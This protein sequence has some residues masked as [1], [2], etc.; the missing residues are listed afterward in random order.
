MPSNATELHNHVEVLPGSRG[1]PLRPY[2][3][4]HGA[5]T[6][7]HSQMEISSASDHSLRIDIVSKLPSPLKE[8]VSTAVHPSRDRH[9]SRPVYKKETEVRP[10]SRN[11]APQP[12]LTTWRLLTALFA[13]PSA[14]S[15]TRAP[16][17]LS[18]VRRA[19]FCATSLVRR[20][21]G[22]ATS[23]IVSAKSMCFA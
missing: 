8:P 2:L 1:G 17:A 12:R 16:D 11:G 18:G 10:P 22:L 13:T 15:P 9:S 7:A 4:A 23:R 14:S 3:F 5:G 19:T 21:I 20:K 6:L